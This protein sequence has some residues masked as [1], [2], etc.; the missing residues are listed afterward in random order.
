MA[1]GVFYRWNY[2]LISHPIKQTH[3]HADRATAGRAE[4]LLQRGGA[5]LR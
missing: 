4:A 2:D 3:V 5:G 1:M